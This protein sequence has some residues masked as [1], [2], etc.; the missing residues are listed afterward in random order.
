MIRAIALLCSSLVVL[1]GCSADPATEASVPETLPVVASFYPLEWVAQR[2]GG[3]Q[4]SVTGLTPAG[5]EPHDLVLGPRA[6]QATDQAAVVLYLGSSFQPDVERTVDQLAAGVQRVDLLASPGIHLRPAPSDLGTESL[7]GGKDPHVWLDPVRVSLMADR[8]ADAIVAIRPDLEEAVGRR[9]TVLKADLATLD[10]ELRTE[11]TTCRR[12][13]IVTSHAA[14]GYLAERYHLKQ[15]AIAGISPDAE[16][17]PSAL[18]K[19]ADSARQAGV[20]TVFFEEA[21]PPHLAKTVAEEIGAST[22]LLGALE[23]DPAAAVGPGED[24]L[25]VM[26]RNGK[27]L[28]RGLGC[29]S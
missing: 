3:N 6:R 17:D 1:T 20:T 13:T 5:A 16:P 28:S 29:A 18:R 21:L 10:K 22:D 19:V 14:F 2:L 23:F 8:A 4:V 26:R 15:I 12:R 24:Y 7:D 25:S 9:L 27:A 11:L